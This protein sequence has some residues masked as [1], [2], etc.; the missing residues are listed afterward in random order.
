[1]LK[2]LGGRPKMTW[3]EVV[4]K[5]MTAYDFTKDMT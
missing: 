3:V 4:G 1:M 5:D 2:T